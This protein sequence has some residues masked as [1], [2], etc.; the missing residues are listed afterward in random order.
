[1]YKKFLTAKGRGYRGTMAAWRPARRTETEEVYKLLDVPRRVSTYSK[2]RF[3][4]DDLV[5]RPVTHFQGRDSGVKVEYYEDDR[6]RARS[7]KAV[8]YGRIQH[9]FK[10]RLHNGPDS[11][12]RIVL[13]VEWFD[14][15]VYDPLTTLRR[16]TTAPDSNYN[17]HFRLTFL[18]GIVPTNRAFWPV[19]TEEADPQEF[20]VIER[21]VFED[22][23]GDMT[24]YG[25]EDEEGAG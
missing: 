21:W 24:A 15:H 10:H 17:K 1:V 23:K 11:P 3:K 7:V 5:Y 8:Q 19:D 22:L 9:I 20:Y 12:E 6:E 4:H 2:I 14:K 18:P 25:D 13:D 16:V